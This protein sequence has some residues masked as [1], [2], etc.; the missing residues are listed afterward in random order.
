[1][2]FAL[3]ILELAECSN[4]MGSK[5]MGFAP[6]VKTSQEGDGVIKGKVISS[7]KL[8]S[9]GNKFAHLF[10]QQSAAYLPFRSKRE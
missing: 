6:A 3:F 9:D 10:R 4:N 1:M 8:F 2:S 7:S 5:Y